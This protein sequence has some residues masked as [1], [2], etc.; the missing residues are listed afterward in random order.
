MISKSRLYFFVLL[1]ISLLSVRTTSAQPVLQK[2]Y[3][4]V[5][6]IPSVI[7]MDSSPSHL[8]VLSDKEGMVVFRTPA[9]SD[10]LQWL[11]SSTGMERRGNTMTADIRFA[12]LFGLNRRLTV[13]EPTSVLGVYSS[14]MLSDRPLDAKRVNRFL[15]VA[16]GERGLGRLSLDTPS[17]VDSTVTLVERSRLRDENIIDLETSLGQLF[18]LSTESRLFV[19]NRQEDSVA[20]SKTLDLPRNLEHIFVI[21]EVLLGSDPSGNIYEIESSGNLA[22]LGSI[23]EPVRQIESWRS[24]LIIKGR[25]NRLWT[26]YENRS[27]VLWKKESNAGNYFTITG[28]QFWLCEYN[29]ISRV[30]SYSQSEAQPVADGEPRPRPGPTTDTLSLKPIENVTVP[31]PRPVLLALELA[32]N[33]PAEQ[34]QF[35]YRSNIREAQIKGNGFYW[36]PQASDVGSHLFNIIAS[37]TDGQVD[38]TGFRVDVR[39][40]NAPPKF[41]PIRPIT[42]PVGE[43]FTMPVKA[44]DPDGMNPNLVRYLGV[45]LPEGSSVDEHTGVF[46]W[47]PS[48]RQTG[49]NSFQ[50]IATDQYGAASQVDISIRVIEVSQSGE[51]GDEGE[52]G[53]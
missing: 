17:S 27:P 40:F 7:A 10:T 39:S 42:I 47:T 26:S 4:Y 12:Y 21:G 23:G 24:W 1:L 25:S 38:S 41:S 36:Q 52:T 19:F 34:V 49:K 50:I 30:V 33:Y 15:Y 51:D 32:G 14:T 28:N 16:M 53:N 8:Y 29:Q 9:E 3:S 2:D 43:P 37:S 20:F 13:L 46:S 35:T 18:A 44:T 5:L 48:A 22:K 31:Y 11:Y 6:E 45:D